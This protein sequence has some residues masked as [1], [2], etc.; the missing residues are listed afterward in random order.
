M[1]Y[2]R[3]G[4]RY[5]STGRDLYVFRCLEHRWLAVWR[6]ILDVD[7]HV[8]HNTSRRNRR[9]QAVTEDSSLSQEIQELS[10][11]S[12]RLLHVH[13]VGSYDAFAV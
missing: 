8:R 5:I 10:V 2:E 13:H 3:S 1:S 11:E 7:E 12:F 9:R 6:T 4:K